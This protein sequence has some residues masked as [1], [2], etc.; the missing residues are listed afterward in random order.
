MEYHQGLAEATEIARQAF[1]EL[2]RLEIPPHP[3]NFAVWYEYFLGRSDDLNAELDAVRDGR[4]TYSRELAR[5]LYETYVA[6]SELHRLQQIEHE[7][8]SLLADTLE[9]MTQAGVDVSKFVAMLHTLSDKLERNESIDQIRAT[10]GNL[11]AETEDL[12]QTHA[13]YEEQLSTSTGEIALLREELDRVRE[14]AS[15]D[16][17]TGLANRKMLDETLAAR[18]EDLDQA[19]PGLCLVMIDI[20]RFKVVNDAHG[21]LVG[22]KVLKFLA[23]T[24]EQMV[25]GKDLVARYGGEEFVIVLQD[26]TRPDAVKLAEAIRRTLERA[27]L[28]RNDTGAP[29]GQVTISAGV[30]CAGPGDHGEALIGRADRA[31]YHSKR[32]GRN[33]V[34][35]VAESDS[36]DGSGDHGGAVAPGAGLD[37]G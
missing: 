9:T 27:R 16:P 13:R 24:L 34:S 8:S 28:R 25:K 29:I 32:R 20:D 22:D 4:K 5:S 12:V 30:A 17:L 33:R 35:W 23:N 21:H 3:T 31:L 37:A 14:Q 6:A 2:A 11:L 1:A 26:V 10:I 15:R 7:V 18:L 19:A 36:G